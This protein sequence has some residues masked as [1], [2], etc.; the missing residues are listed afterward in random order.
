MLPRNFV[1][2]ALS[3]K[4]IRFDELVRI[5]LNLCAFA[6][7][8]A[9]AAREYHVLQTRHSS[10]FGHLVQHRLTVA[11]VSLLR[12]ERLARLSRLRSSRSSRFCQLRRLRGAGAQRHAGRACTY[13]SQRCGYAFRRSLLRLVR[14]RQLL[15]GRRLE[16]LDVLEWR[17][18]GAPWASVSALYVVNQGPTGPGIVVPYRTYSPDTA[19]APAADYPYVPGYARPYYGRYAFRDPAYMNPH[20]QHVPPRRVLY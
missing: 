10:G 19:Y 14:L 8:R 6:A 5:H 12:G 15:L 13:R 11:G 16:R 7:S 20:Y 17:R 4:R 2:Q 18:G 1:P 9:G 3:H